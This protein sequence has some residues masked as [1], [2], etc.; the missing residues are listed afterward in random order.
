MRR[1]AL[2]RRGLAPLTPTRTPPPTRPHP[3][4][5]NEGVVSDYTPGSDTFHSRAARGPIRVATTSTSAGAGIGP[6]RPSTATHRTLEWAAVKEPRLHGCAPGYSRY[7]KSER[8]GRFATPRR[9]GSASPLFAAM[10]ISPTTAPPSICRM[11]TS[12]YPSSS[13]L[14]RGRPPLH[15]LRPDIPA[16]GRRIQRR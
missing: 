2:S 3:R 1:E 15:A 11:G 4:V 8:L 12:S 13:A 9:L 10:A 14:P 5:S 6:I 7:P 16:V